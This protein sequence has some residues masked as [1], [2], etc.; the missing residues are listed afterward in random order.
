MAE[1]RPIGVDVAPKKAD[2]CNK[3]R[4]IGTSPVVIGATGR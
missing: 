2:S 3:H 4:P 1:I